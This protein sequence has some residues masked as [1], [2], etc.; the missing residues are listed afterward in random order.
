[1]SK[2][3]RDKHVIL[4]NACVVPILKSLFF[5]GLLKH[6]GYFVE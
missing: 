1:M 6:I 5:N 2:V 4:I 3:N